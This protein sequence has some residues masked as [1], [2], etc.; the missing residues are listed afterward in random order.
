LHFLR[1]VRLRKDDLAIV[2]D[3]IKLLGELKENPNLRAQLGD[4][5]GMLRTVRNR[6]AHPVEGP[7]PAYALDEEDTDA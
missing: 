2:T 1:Q 5:A 4:V 3:A 6:I 7:R